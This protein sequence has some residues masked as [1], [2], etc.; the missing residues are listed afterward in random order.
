MKIVDFVVVWNYY[1][2]VDWACLGVSIWNFTGHAQLL[3]SHSFHNKGANILTL[4]LSLQIALHSYKRTKINIF[5]LTNIFSKTVWVWVKQSILKVISRLF[6]DQAQVWF[7]ESYFTEAITI[8][9]QILTLKNDIFWWL[10][11]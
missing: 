4:V 10:K 3:V 6:C 5:S 8:S 2:V 9:F 7:V 1:I 11:W